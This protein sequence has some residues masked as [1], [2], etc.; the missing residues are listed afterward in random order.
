[1]SK[2]V[3]MQCAVNVNRE[4]VRRQT[5]N[6][7][8]HIVIESFT[9]PDNVIMNGGLYGAEEIASSYQT[10]ERTLAPVEHPQDASGNFLSATDPIA[11]HDY[12]AGAFNANV[13]R[14]NG[15]VKIEKHINVQEALKSEKGK[16][17]LDRIEELETNADAR[18]NHTSVGVF[19][20]PEELDTPVTNA[21]GDIYS[22]VAREMSFDHDAILLDSIGAAKPSQ[23]VGIGVNAEG[24][25]CEVQTFILNE[26]QL[27]AQEVNQSFDETHTAVIDALRKAAIVADFQTMLF[28]RLVTPYT[29]C[30]ILKKRMAA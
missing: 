29:M 26:A 5:I 22:W 11:I 30:R 4:A 14:E 24:D 18:P 19:L 7:V 17:L 6:G 13:S 3:M 12:H 20:I 15:R 9:L 16:R 25:Q 1:M 23:G 21:E 2:K 28:S 27:V 10:L 8:E